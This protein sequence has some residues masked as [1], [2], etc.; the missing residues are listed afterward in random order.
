[1]ARFAYYDR[2][3]ESA[4]RTYRKSDAI[5]RIEV[6]GVDELRPH[7]L[8]LEPALA[9]A[10]RGEV[11]RACQAIVDGV[12]ARLG[13]PPVIVRV[14]ERRPSS[15]WGELHGLYEPDEVTG[16]TARITLWMRTASREQVVKFRTFLRTLAHEL[17]HHLDYEHFKLAETFHTQG[18]YARESA[19]VRELLGEPSPRPSPKGEGD[20][21]KA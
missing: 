18:F 21:P 17:C 10:E 15:D 20:H 11:E 2:L 5:A 12:N 16:G 6:P 1:V 19:L 7:A 14:L 8:A 3:S 13:A 4:K 9:D